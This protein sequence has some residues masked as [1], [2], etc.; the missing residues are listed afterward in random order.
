MDPHAEIVRL[1]ARI[2]QLEREKADIE[3]FAALAAHE[4][5][6]PVV[7]IDACAAS[8]SDRLDSDERHAESIHDLSVVRR[9]CM[10]SRVLVESLLHHSVLRDRPLEPRRVEL[11]V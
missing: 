11:D 1:R 6:T 8:V 4:L 5:L 2:A 9:G 3:G 7:M 10:H